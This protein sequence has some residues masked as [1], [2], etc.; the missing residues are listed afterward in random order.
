MVGGDCDCNVGCG[1]VC[2]RCVIVADVPVVVVMC[3]VVDV[4]V[5]VDHCVDVVVVVVVYDG[6][7]LC[8]GC[9]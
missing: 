5:S 1:V 6:I 8:D 2:V 9:G 7:A 4:T 3:G